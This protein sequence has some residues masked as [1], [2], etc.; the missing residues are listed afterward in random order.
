MYRHHFDVI[1][2]SL[3]CMLSAP[4][5]INLI[6][7]IVKRAVVVTT[8]RF[9][10]STLHAWIRFFFHCLLHISYRLEIKNGKHEWKKINEGYQIIKI[11]RG[12]F[13]NE[14]GVLASE[15]TPGGSG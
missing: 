1:C 2:S 13:K 8:Y 15:F 7:E 5:L 6:D 11:F 14:M 10:L 4:K 9:G 12:L 3:Q